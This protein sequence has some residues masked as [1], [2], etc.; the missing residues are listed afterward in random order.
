MLKLGREKKKKEEKGQVEIST[1][2]RYLHF[3]QLVFNLGYL[4]LPLLFPQ[5]VHGCFV[6]LLQTSDLILNA[7]IFQSNIHKGFLVG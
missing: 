3:Q 4:Q 5:P 2:T 7:A 6:C 1:P